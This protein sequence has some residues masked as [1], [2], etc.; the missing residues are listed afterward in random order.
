MVCIEGSIVQYVLGVLF[1]IGGTG[2]YIPQ[3]IT[4]LR[5]ASSKGVSELSLFLL[6]IAGFCLSINAIVLNW[7]D[8]ECFS[9]CDNSLICFANLLSVWQIIGGWIM[10]GVVY[11]LFLRF[12]CYFRGQRCGGGNC[13]RHCIEH[14]CCFGF[15]RFQ[16]KEIKKENIDIENSRSLDNLAEI[17]DQ[18]NSQDFDLEIDQVNEEDDFDSFEELLNEF[19]EYDGIEDTFFDD[20]DEVIRIFDWLLA[21]TYV[22]FIILLLI[23][24]GVEKKTGSQTFFDRFAMAMGVINAILTGCVWIPQIIS[25]IRTKSTEGVSIIMFILQA[26]GSAVIVIFQA[27]I[28]KQA[29]S[30]WIGYAVSSAEQFIILGIV[31]WIKIKHRNSS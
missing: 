8:F 24:I 7:N 30:T 9:E 14:Q 3:C 11:I 18:E 16:S 29:V 17:E 10:T 5:A 19:D 12:R 28:Y 13:R 15:R 1:F 23:F 2:S 27:F 31:L 20:D 6:G 4:L 22:I 21:A 25:L 26:P